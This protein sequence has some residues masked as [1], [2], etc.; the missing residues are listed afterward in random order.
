VEPLGHF[1][2]FGIW[3]GRSAVAPERL[4][5]RLARAVIQATANLPSAE[6]WAQAYRR[7]LTLPPPMLVLP[8]LPDRRDLAVVEVLK[9]ALEEVGV[10]TRVSPNWPQG[11]DAPTVAIRP[12][13]VLFLGG[14]GEADF[15]RLARSVVV[16]HATPGDAA[17]ARDL[18]FILGAAGVAST[19]ADTATL[20]GRSG[21]PSLWLRPPI[22]GGIEPAPTGP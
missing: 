16:T 22:S 13:Q 9:A 2:D 10:P 21:A 17:F 19:C 7:C 11:C 4:S 12:D 18:P 3:E 15:R 8:P 6:D 14:R 1:A 20:L 5:G